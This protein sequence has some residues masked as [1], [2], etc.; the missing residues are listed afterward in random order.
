MTSL[1]ARTPNPI[2]ST[3]PASDS[4]LVPP[5]GDD[6]RNDSDRDTRRQVPGGIWT[7]NGAPCSPNTVVSNSLSTAQFVALLY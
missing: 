6:E 2:H 7:C 5:A 4:R 3:G 1:L